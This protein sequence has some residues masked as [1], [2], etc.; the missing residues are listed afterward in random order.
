MKI[1]TKAGKI[2]KKLFF[3]SNTSNSCETLSKSKADINNEPVNFNTNSSGVQSAYITDI[4]GSVF[5]IS[6]FPFVIGRLPVTEG[7]NLSLP[8][9]PEI[10]GIH[11]RIIC[12][13]GMYYIEDCDSTNG[14]FVSD[15]PDNQT[16]QENRITKSELHDG[17]R[18]FIYHS[19]F[20]FHT[21]SRSEQTCIIK[22]NDN[23]QTAATLPVDAD[24][25]PYC[26]ACIKDEDGNIITHVKSPAFIFHSDHDLIIETQNDKY[27]ISSGDSSSFDYEGELI[28][29]GRKAELFSGCRFS[30]RDKKYRF[31]IK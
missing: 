2:F 16:G 7:T 18:F 6:D 12:E 21:D 8:D 24:T 19:E 25:E 28:E 27:Y 10:S 4:N 31:Y 14:T 13:D 9:V 22:H 11:A 26:R 15:S 23:Y 29:P 3:S 30:C 1:L 5:Y 20:T 17:Y